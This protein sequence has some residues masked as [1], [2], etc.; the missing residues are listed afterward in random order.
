METGTASGAGWARTDELKSRT[1][2]PNVVSVKET[3]A[4]RCP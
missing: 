4:D 3:M 2:K 1:E